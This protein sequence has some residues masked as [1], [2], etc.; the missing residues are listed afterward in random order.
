MLMLSLANVPSPSSL[1]PTWT[2]V[3]GCRNL[4][5]YLPDNNS[6]RSLAGSS[7][8]WFSGLLQ[9][10]R[11]AALLRQVLEVL[12]LTYHVCAQTRVIG[13]LRILARGRG[14][15]ICWQRMLQWT[16]SHIS[17]WTFWLALLDIHY[18]FLWGW[19]A[20]PMQRELIFDL[21]VRLKATQ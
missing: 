11:C 21:R 7:F 12:V 14:H 15:L 3:F 17:P 13:P 16:A 4:A 18:Y 2:V 1:V 19:P 5:F 8:C 6:F 20:V 10:P 9:W